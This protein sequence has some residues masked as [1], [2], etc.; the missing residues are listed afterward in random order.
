MPQCQQG[1]SLCDAFGGQ[2]YFSWK[3]LAW[4]KPSLTL[5][6]PT[7]SKY[8]HWHPA[9]HRS[10]TGREMARL[11]SFPDS[12]QFVGGFKEWGDRIGNSV[13]PNLMRAIA[14]HIVDVLLKKISETG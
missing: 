2:K 5:A 11:A 9:E 7:F 3:R 12:F 4:D 10:I 8:S 13:P 14:A 6:R 1:K